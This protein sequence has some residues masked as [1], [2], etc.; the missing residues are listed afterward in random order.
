MTLDRRFI[1]TAGAGLGAAAASAYAGDARPGR[2]PARVTGFVAVQG[3][4]PNAERDQTAVLQAAIDEA[5]ATG[6]PVML[7]PGVFRVTDLRLRP[8]TRLIGAAR[9]SVLQFSGGTAFITGEKAD[10][11]LL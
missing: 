8:A 11:L 7:P 4:E 6:V 3:L 2:E 5:A 10:G 1:L 9:T